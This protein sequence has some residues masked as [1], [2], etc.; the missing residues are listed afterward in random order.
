MTISSTTRKAGPYVGN[1]SATSFAFAFKVFAKADIEVKLTVLSTGAISTLVLDTDYTV[2][3]NADQ[4][5]NPGGTVTY[6]P[7]GTPMPS[8]KTLTITS[9]VAAT[10]GTDITNGGGFYPDV[11]E[12]MADRATIGVQQNAEAIARSLQFPIV[13]AA[14]TATLPTAAL[15]ANKAVV[16]DASGNV[17]VSTD[18]FNNSATAAAASAAAAASSASSASTSASTAT[19]QAGIA[20]AKAVLTAADAV[21][22]AADVI[23]AA[24]SASAASSSASAAS[25]SA[26]T[27]T[28]QASNA[29]TS[30]SNASTS[31]ST[32]T[33]QASNAS[34]SASTATTQAGIATT[35]AGN[36]STSASAAAAS[37]AAAL[38]SENN[39]AATIGAVGGITSTA[40]AAGTTTLTSA[41]AQTQQFTGTTTQNCDLPVA[42]TLLAGRW[43][44]IINDSTGVVT[45]RSSGGNTVRA[46]AAGE[47]T[48]VLLLVASGTGA[49]SWSTPQAGVFTTVT[50]TGST[51]PANGMYLPAAN[52][53]G[54][55]TNSTRRMS[56]DSSGNLMVGAAAAPTTNDTY[57]TVELGIS[58][59]GAIAAANQSG[60]IAGMYHSGGNWLY[61]NSSYAPSLYLQSSGTHAWY[62]ASSG[63][64]GNNVSLTQAMYLSAVGY[65][66]LGVSP[67]YPLHINKSIN[68]YFSVFNNSNAAPYGQVWSYTGAA[69]NSTAQDFLICSDTGGT[70]M[71][72]HSNGNLV[73]ANN[74][75]GATSD[76]KLKQDIELAGTQLDDVLALSRVVSKFRFKSDPNGPLQLGWVAQDV[77]AISPGLVTASPDEERVPVEDE[78]GNIVRYE[79]RDLGT[80]T[81]AV[82]HSVAHMKLF[83]AFGELHD[84]FD[85][86]LAAIEAALNISH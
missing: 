81:L 62:T 46:V 47:T 25:T 3:L 17:G 72:I 69:P 63:T 19:T 12:D 59:Y 38:V 42:S 84:G 73:N 33:T 35:Q 23:A 50:V 79:R 43:F 10:Q 8:T 37:A 18:D 32:A 30:A 15:R 65:L 28:T 85:A 64:A 39:A 29:S 52:T 36:A 27:A 20:T 61:A 83:K 48:I 76:R 14:L 66:G 74:S 78:E 13:D 44:R 57:T 41:S 2:T 21:S 45:V 22:T 86:R 49:S 75:Y 58:G 24:A 11:I 51:A 5:A 34:T 7:S 60:L 80:V 4:N 1:S 16:F 70:R 55:S 9:I 68:D 54:W 56:L 82:Q 40:T 77:Q 6:N 31:A 67:V 53:L 26:S 71:M